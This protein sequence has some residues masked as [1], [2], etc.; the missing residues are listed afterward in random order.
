VC[1]PGGRARES[2][3]SSHVAAEVP[4][5]RLRAS[6]VS[7]PASGLGVVVETTR[8]EQ[9]VLQRPSAQGMGET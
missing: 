8:L 6:S 7:R 2:I 1:G 4:R 3:S 9:R 5:H